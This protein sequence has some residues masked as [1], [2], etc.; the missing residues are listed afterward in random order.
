[1]FLAVAG[2]IP[3]VPLLAILLPIE[4]MLKLF[5]AVLG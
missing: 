3:M 4:Q 2:L 5:L 1:V